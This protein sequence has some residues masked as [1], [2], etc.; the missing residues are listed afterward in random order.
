[1]IIPN[2]KDIY[3]TVS[4]K[5]GLDLELVEKIGSFTWS[6]LN[7][8]ISEFK[9]REIYMYKLGVWKFRKVKGEEHLNYLRK[10]IA[11]VRKNT[12]YTD[13]EKERL[14]NKIV[15]K[16]GK[17]AILLNE[18]DDIIEKRKQFKDEQTQRDISK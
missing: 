3:K 2:H 5:Y 1:M 11:K 14:I 18:W 12:N 4:E 7:D 10:E 9:N 16:I 13:K 6:D 17:I 8:R 15:E